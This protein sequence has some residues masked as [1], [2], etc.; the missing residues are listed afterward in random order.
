MMRSSLKDPVDR[1]CIKRSVDRNIPKPLKHA[2]VQ[3]ARQPLH[4]L[5]C[6]LQ[7]A[8]CLE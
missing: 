1:V 5:M 7:I 4:H 8:A 3:G 2:G 6:L